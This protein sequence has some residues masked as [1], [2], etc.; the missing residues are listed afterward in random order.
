MR[1]KVFSN[2]LK[3]GLS[4]DDV[5]Y[6]WQSPIRCRQRNGTDDP[7]IWIAIGVLPNGK[8][9]EMVAFQDIDGFWCVFHAMTPPTKKFILEL[10]LKGDKHGR[11]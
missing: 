6:A 7:A 1:I 3:H 9:A 2:A 10:G 4:E 5:L 8:M 11:G